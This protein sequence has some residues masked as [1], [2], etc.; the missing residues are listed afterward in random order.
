MPTNHQHR[1]RQ[2][3]RSA[4]VR[5]LSRLKITALT[6]STL[7]FGG[8]V[9]SLASQPV[10]VHAVASAAISSTQAT[11]S[12]TAAAAAPTTATAAAVPAA[13]AAPAATVT[14]PI[15]SAQS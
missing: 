2:E 5:R 13:T 15:V 4:A 3:L 11:S 7:A 12:P 9:A 14:Q 6:V 8:F 10:V 1:I